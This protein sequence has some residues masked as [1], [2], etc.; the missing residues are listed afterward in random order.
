M[1][2]NAPSALMTTEELFALPENG[3]ERELI[4]GQLL[5]RPMTRRNRWH[6]RTMGRIGHL[7]EGWLE[8]QPEPRGEVL[9]GDAMFRLKRDPDTTVGIDLAYVSAELTAKTPANMGFFDGIP[10][11]AIEILSPSDQ[12]EDVTA[13][14][15]LYL[16]AGIPLVWYVDPDF[17]VIWVHR[18]NAE[19]ESFN[20]RQEI[21]ADPYLPGFRVPVAKIF[22]I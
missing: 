16:D 11:L 7:L 15:R 17:R 13:K 10:V 14:I 22:G 5:E 9:V 19:P 6:S 21:S 18:S 12:H 3:V 20:I 1:N 4:R 8:E 2:A